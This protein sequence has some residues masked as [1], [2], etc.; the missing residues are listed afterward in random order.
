MNTLAEY[1]GLAAFLSPVL[2][3]GVLNA[4]LALLGERGTLMFPSLR[5]FPTVWSPRAVQRVEHVSHP[6]AA[7]VAGEEIEFRKAA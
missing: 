5:P 4:A 7:D 3:I 1:V 2:L 6:R